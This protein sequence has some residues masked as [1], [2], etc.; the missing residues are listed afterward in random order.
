MYIYFPTAL[1]TISKTTVPFTTHTHKHPLC[2]RETFLDRQ[3]V[4]GPCFKVLYCTFPRGGREQGREVDSDPERP[5]SFP[6][7]SVIN[8]VSCDYLVV[9]SAI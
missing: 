4:G 3:R 1:Q 9:L 6:V 8:C 2:H 7:A 5:P